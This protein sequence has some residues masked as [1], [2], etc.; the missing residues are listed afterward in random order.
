V[1]ARVVGLFRFLLGVEVVQV[2]VELVEPVHRGQE[3]VAITQV[4]LADLRGRVA[5]RLQ[6]LGQ[7]RILR[8]QPLRRTRHTDRRQAGAHGQLPG[9]QGGPAVGAAGL[10]VAV[11]EPGTFGRDPVDIGCP[12][13]HDPLVVAA[14]VIPADIVGQDD[15]HVRPTVRH[16][17]SNGSRRPRL[18]R[19]V[20]ARSTVKQDPARTH[21]PNRVI[22]IR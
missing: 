13:A 8:L 14:D 3:L 21:H 19:P 11:G 15:H 10:G 22:H 9:D 2:A 18:E 6:Q 1:V 16:L 20:T 5:E 17:S 4:V 12:C 7:R